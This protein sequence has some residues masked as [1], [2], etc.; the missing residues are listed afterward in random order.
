VSLS[1]SAGVALVLAFLFAHLAFLPK[2]LED[3]DSINFAL[4]VR[5]FNVA[6][7]QPHP[8][9]YP[10]FIALSKASTAV[11]RMAGIDAA[12]TRGLAI[13]SALGGAAAIP[14]IFLLLRRLEGRDDLSR[15]ATLVLVA[16]PL[17]WFTALRPLS[18]M[19]GF[20][21]AMWALALMAGKPPPRRL[22]AGALLAGFTIGIRSQVAVLTL[23]MLVCALVVDRQSRVR[24]GALAAF[25]GGALVWAVP[26]I[27]ASGGVSQYLTALGSQAGGDLGGG[28]VILWTHHTVRDAAHALLNTFIWP[29]DWWLGIAVCL[30]AAIGAARIAWRAPLVLLLIVVVFGPYAIFHLLFQE[31]ETTRYALPLLPVIAYAAMA[32]VEG[33]PARALPVAA[34]GL[35]VIALMQA[36][37]ASMHYARE[38][39]P[40]FRAFD[41]MAATA[42]GGDRVDRIALHAS[43]RRAAEWATPILPA[44]VVLAPHGYE[45]LTLVE[46]WK[47]EPSARVW[48]VADPSRT[49]L[50]L[51][52]PRARDL[53]RAYHWGFIEPP[54]VGGAR[55]SNI[56]WYRM[57][58]PNWMLDRGWSITA[59]VG[60]TSARDGA[61]PHLKP[62]I[63]WLKRQPQEM[64]V[65]LGGRHQGATGAKPVTLTVS[66]KGATVAALQLP[67]GFFLHLITLPAGALNTTDNYVPLAVTS[68]GD[69]HPIVSLEQFDAQP[70]GVPMFGYDA[71]FHEPEFNLAEGRAWRWMSEKAALWV[72]PVG[73]AVT[74]RLIGES[75]ARQLGAVPHVRVLIGDREVA[76]FD[77]EGDFDQTVTLPADVLE[78]A[79]GHVVLESSKFFVPA[80][81]G[82]ADQRHLAL[83]I[84]RVGID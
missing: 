13:W 2:T 6:E 8:P 80:A 72:R 24:L 77:P 68:A 11:L 16:S 12:S 21:A 20:A 38:G 79:N 28:V 44:R 83:R 9:G 25:T 55:P 65:L 76:A 23:P 48:F 43:A 67:P 15:W 33:L 10:V 31:T 30:L 49:D 81:G 58:P 40:V 18:D 78:R 41:D 42:H 57:Q 26:L 17:F 34:I 22:V 75:P 71:G 62:A 35:S 19:L 69:D 5:Q 46:L 51:F 63:A 1:R 82:A 3:I 53:A 47:A 66:L 14:A 50:E 61:G 32:A 54:F 37:P 7:H 74:L 36:L 59:E 60:G 64:T 70:Q 56:D 39:A 29:W 73:R 52:D 4:G 84:F 45:W 27:V